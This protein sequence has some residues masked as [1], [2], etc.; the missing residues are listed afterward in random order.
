MYES[1]SIMGDMKMKRKSLCICNA[2]Q[3]AAF[4]DIFRS[5]Q[6]GT[7]CCLLPVSSMNF[8]FSS[9]RPFDRNF[10]KFKGMLLPSILMKNLKRVV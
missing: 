1:Q 4:C 2:F 9:R 10:L 6:R 8:F 7:Y 3:H 5:P